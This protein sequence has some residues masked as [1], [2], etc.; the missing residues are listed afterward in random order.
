VTVS[1]TTA[2]ITSWSGVA[3]SPRYC[4]TGRL[5][6]KGEVVVRV[7]GYAPFVLTGVILLDQGYAYLNVE[8]TV[9]DQR[10]SAAPSRFPFVCAPR[11]D[12][13]P[14]LTGQITVT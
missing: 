13:A 11:V 4:A 3:D 8:G 9:G 2:G 12:R 7:D 5:R 14:V 1:G 6:S 10:L